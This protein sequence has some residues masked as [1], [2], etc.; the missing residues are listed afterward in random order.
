M[1]RCLAISI[2]VAAACLSGAHAA[3][4][5]G[6]TRTQNGSLKNVAKADQARR[7]L[8]S[9]ANSEGATSLPIA[10]LGYAAYTASIGIGNPPT[11]YNLLVD[12]GS[13]N[14]WIGGNKPYVK[15]ST[16][17]PTG[18]AVNVSNAGGAFVGSEYYD[19]VAL[20]PGLII[21]NQSIADATGAMAPPGVD[22]I[23]GFG[24]VNLTLQTF[25]N[26]P[27]QTIPTVMNNAYAQKIIPE[28]V[29]G[30]YFAPA[31]SNYSMNGQLTFGGVDE[32]LCVGPIHW[33]PVTTTKFADL[34]WGVNI[35]ASYGRKTLIPATHSGIIDTSS[36]LTGVLDAWY[37]TYIKAIPG[38]FFDANV[39]GLTAIP[40]SSVKHMHMIAIFVEGQPLLWDVEAQLAP[41]SL[42]TE[43]GG[44]SG[45]R[46]SYIVPIG[47]AF[48]P[49]IDFILGMSFIE[50]FY[51]V[52]PCFDL[53]PRSDVEP[54][55][56]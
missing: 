36:T 24:P 46:Y 38:S 9:R 28:Q 26:N 21:R 23:I 56:L 48:L 53:M 40:E 4:S 52:S 2:V 19:E 10:Q 12:S 42:A 25:E 1:H 49:G 20:A 18:E 8:L 5:V 29:L 51:T 47:T 35:S 43:L 7:A 22:G 54:F 6:L 14:T 27:M 41:K 17:V 34:Y 55:W 39:T 32:S 31:T 50:R 30:V 33:T 16:S 44:E 13:S 11:Y 37:E 15:T 3:I 45:F